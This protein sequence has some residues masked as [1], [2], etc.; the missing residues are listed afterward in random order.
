MG[1]KTNILATLKLIFE[2]KIFHTMHFPTKLSCDVIEIS[3]YAVYFENLM[4]LL[5]LCVFL[6]LHFNPEYIHLD[7]VKI[8][9]REK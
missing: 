7:W 4:I 1:L 9:S 5:A 8:G 2:I 6:T 3:G